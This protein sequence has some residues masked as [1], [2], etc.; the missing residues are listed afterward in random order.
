MLRLRS[1][2]LDLIEA[3]V[4][5]RLGDQQAQWDPRPALGVV[6]AAEGY[7]GTPRTGDAINAWDAPDVEDTKVFHAG[8]RMEGD[9]AVTAG[10][11]VLCVCA[12]GDTVA[13]AQR[14]AYAE[15]AG[16]SWPG[17]FHRHDIGWRAIERE[18]QGA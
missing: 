7:P 13:D 14:K 12:L 18:R 3:A 5:G 15:L 11:R 2:L 4:D 16:I 10:G 9:H 8:T 1:D 6:M 17:E